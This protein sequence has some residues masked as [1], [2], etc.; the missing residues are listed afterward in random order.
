LQPQ[1][2]PDALSVHLLKRRGPALAHSLCLALPP[3]L[4]G[5]VSA[6]ARARQAAA[7]TGQHVRMGLVD[8][9]GGRPRLFSGA[10]KQFDMVWVNLR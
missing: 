10:A 1:P 9:I 2:D 4:A 5:V 7:V 6:R 8:D 3:V